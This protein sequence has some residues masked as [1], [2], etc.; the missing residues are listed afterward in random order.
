MKAILMIAAVMLANVVWAQNAAPELTAVVPVPHLKQSTLPGT[1]TEQPWQA[2]RSG[3]VPEGTTTITG[4]F[5]DQVPGG[6]VLV[7]EHLSVLIAVNGTADFGL[8]SVAATG[9]GAI[10]M[11]PCPRIGQT[12]SVS[13]FSCSTQTKI[14]IPPGERPVFTVN[15]GANVNTLGTWDWVAFASGHYEI[16]K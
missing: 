12:P 16:V 4:F 10:D 5:S 7:I 2:P 8:V 11:L 3:T 15:L 9:G 6:K 14:F 1:T 13:S